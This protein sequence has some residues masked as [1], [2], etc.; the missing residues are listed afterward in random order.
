[1]RV[2]SYLY[3]LHPPTP[4]IV[5]VSNIHHILCSLCKH[6]THN[7]VPHWTSSFSSTCSPVIISKYSS[8][9]PL[10]PGVAQNGQ[11]IH[12]DVDNV[13]VKIQC[14]KDVLLGTDGILVLAAHHHLCIVDQIEA[15]E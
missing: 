4:Y 10:I 14:S 5:P 15:K 1:M 9:F 7:T 3:P 8:S 13:H 2:E 6:H 11:N 12:E